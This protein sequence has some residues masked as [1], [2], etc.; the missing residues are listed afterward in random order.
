MLF[1]QAIAFLY[2]G[3]SKIELHI[4]L[5]II[6]KAFYHSNNTG[7]VDKELNIDS[8]PVTVLYLDWIAIP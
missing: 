6:Y 7:F 8:T 4:C 5:E 1:L 3:S 2:L